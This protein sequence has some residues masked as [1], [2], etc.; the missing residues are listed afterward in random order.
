MLAFES[1]ISFG[2]LKYDQPVFTLSS[3]WICISNMFGSRGVMMA[4]EF[5]PKLGTI[6]Q[7]IP[8]FHDI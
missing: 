8:W 3:E 4:E 6:N 5:T 2:L 7:E 1:G